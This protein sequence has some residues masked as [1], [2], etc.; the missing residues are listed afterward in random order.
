MTKFN[1]IESDCLDQQR[2][3]KKIVGLKVLV[4]EKREVTVVNRFMNKELNNQLLEGRF[5]SLKVYLR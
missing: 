5:A 4:N 2:Y 3:R 1:I